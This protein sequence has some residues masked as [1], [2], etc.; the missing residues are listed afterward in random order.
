MRTY[1]FPRPEEPVPRRPA[2][3]LN[4]VC[5]TLEQDPRRE[6]GT[7]QTMVVRKH[8]VKVRTHE[9]SCSP[10]F[11]VVRSRTVAAVID[12][13]V[14]AGL[15]SGAVSWGVVPVSLSYSAAALRDWM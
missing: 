6:G 9:Y 15:P 14:F 4:P 10:S 13:Q 2:P 11:L 5:P 1:L 3:K 8:Q 7:S 12:R